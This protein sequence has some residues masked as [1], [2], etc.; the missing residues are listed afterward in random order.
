MNTLTS[1]RN[2]AALISWSVGMRL[3][4]A[5]AM[6]GALLLNSGWISIILSALLALPS[7]LLI[8]MLSRNDPKK[9]PAALLDGALSIPA[10]KGFSGLLCL[11]SLYEFGTGLR[12]IS[13]SAEFS[14]LDHQPLLLICTASAGTALIACLGGAAGIS[15][16]VQLWRPLYY[17]LMG[18][19]VVVL[20]GSINPAWLFP[21][22]GPGVEQLVLSGVSFGGMQT[23]LLAGW[24]C[25]GEETGESQ[26]GG[27]PYS[28]TGSGLMLRTLVRLSLVSGLLTLIVSMHCPAMPRAPSER[29]F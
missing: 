29:D 14:G 16:T 21:L 20:S 12:L 1:R 11:C 18:L 13:L 8:A 5:T 24:L 27:K 28:L 25:M 17:A 10:R 4:C 9:S 7:A 26:S 2:M 23:G 19:L 15:G 6:D 3:F 22:L